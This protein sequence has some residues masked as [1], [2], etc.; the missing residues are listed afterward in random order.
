MASGGPAAAGG[1]K[2]K[3]TK[4]TP[5]VLRQA[6]EDKAARAKA[7]EEEFDQYAAVR[8]MENSNLMRFIGTGLGT[9]SGPVSWRMKAYWAVFFSFIAG[10]AMYEYWTHNV[11]DPDVAAEVVEVK[12]ARR[13]RPVFSDGRPEDVAK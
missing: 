5:G 4:F 2:P 1:D 10:S 11:A 3:G 8:S 13:R 9:R 7:G 6:P 12:K